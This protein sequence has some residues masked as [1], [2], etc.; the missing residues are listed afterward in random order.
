MQD[1][2]I[3][4]NQPTKE[5][6]IYFIEKSKSNILFDQVQENRAISYSGLPGELIKYELAL[7]GELSLSKNKLLKR[8]RT[9]P[10]FSQLKST[11]EEK[12]REYINLI[13]ELEEKYPDYYELKYA[14]IKNPDGRFAK[15]YTHKAS[16]DITVL[17]GCRKHLYS[18]NYQD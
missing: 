15:D 6:T 12:Q 4:D 5:K 3:M 17:Y 7:K 16:V 1:S 14:D 2:G 8:K 13:S 10:Q 11:Y 9:D 18:C